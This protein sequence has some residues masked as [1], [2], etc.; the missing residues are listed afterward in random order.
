[1]VNVIISSFRYYFSIQTNP[2]EQFYIFSCLCGWLI[3]EK[4]KLE[5]KSELNP[6]DHEDPNVIIAAILDAIELI[7]QGTFSAAKM[8]QGYGMEVSFR[9]AGKIFLRA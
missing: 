1:M 2:G 8:K 5:I 6:Q 7:H 9:K 3:K 4:C